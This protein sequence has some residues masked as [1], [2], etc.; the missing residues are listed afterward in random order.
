MGTI[1]VMDAGGGN[2]QSLAG[3]G[4]PGRGPHHFPTWRQRP[5]ET[6]RARASPTGC[7]DVAFAGKG[8]VQGR[9]SDV[10]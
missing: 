5:R 4:K 8:S 3:K 10:D 7:A 9:T 1:H 2:V 6:Y